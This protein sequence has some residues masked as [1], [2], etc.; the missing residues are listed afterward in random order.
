VNFGHTKLHGHPFS[1]N[2]VTNPIKGIADRNP[3]LKAMNYA[4]VVLK[5]ISLCNLDVHAIGQLANV[6]R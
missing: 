4:S 5:A 3:S 1:Q 2:S 6:M